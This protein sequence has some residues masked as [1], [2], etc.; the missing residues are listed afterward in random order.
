MTELSVRPAVASDIVE[1]YGEPWPFT[2]KALVAILDGKPVG[3]IGISREYGLNKFFSDITP[4]LEPHMK[5]MPILRAIKKMMREVESS[6]LPVVAIAEN[7]AL[8][9]RLGFSQVEGDRYQWASS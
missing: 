8:L 9:E 7:P 3:I 6:R 2:L 5:T 1:F 4:E